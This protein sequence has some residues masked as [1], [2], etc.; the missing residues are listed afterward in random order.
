[1]KSKLLVLLLFI[2]SLLCAQPK[3]KVDTNFHLYLL[4]GQ[5]NMAGRASVDSIST[6]TDPQIYMLD[7]NNQWVLA[8]DP[9][10][11]DKPTVAGVGPG[12]SF[13][14]DML[15]GN[16][17]L[18]IGLIPCAW[19]GSPI[20]VWEPDSAYLT[21]HPYN[22]A[23]ARTTAAMQS[24]I[25]KGILWHQGESDNTAESI[26]V[27][28]EKLKTLTSRLRAAF[29]NLTLPVV[30]G[31]IGYF[32]KSTAINNVLDEVPKTIPNTATVSAKGLTDKGDQIHFDTKSARELGR[33]YA[34]AMKQ[35]EFIR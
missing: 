33:R 8:T 32:G 34:V 30:V 15:A 9:V 23:I 22:D 2:H 12:I 35:L 31:E 5:S 21:G 29:N 3:N 19:G 24:G 20:S 13:A 18:K 4:I 6:I 28:M 27:Y 26:N 25:L 17:Q 7:K 10:H 1:M 11:F 14:K 16:N